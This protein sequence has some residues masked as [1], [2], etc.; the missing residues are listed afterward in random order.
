MQHIHQDDSSFE[1]RSHSIPIGVKNWS[2]TVLCRN[3]DYLVEGSKNLFFGLWPTYLP[4]PWSSIQIPEPPCGRPNSCKQD[5]LETRRASW[6]PLQWLGDV[7]GGSKP[8]HRNIVTAHHKLWKPFS[9][10]M[11]TAPIALES[12]RPDMVDQCTYFELVRWWKTREMMTAS[13][14]D[15][16][17][18]KFIK[19]LKR[20]FHLTIVLPI[21]FAMCAGP[22]FAPFAGLPLAQQYQWTHLCGDSFAGEAIIQS[23]SLGSSRQPFMTFYYP[24]TPD[25]TAKIHY[26]DYVMTND[27]NA[28]TQTL[29]FVGAASQGVVPAD[30]RPNIQSVS[31]ASPGKKNSISAQ[32][33]TTINS[34]SI[35]VP[36]MTGTYQI[37]PYLNFSL[38]DSGNTTYLRA[39]DKEWQFIDDAPSFVLRYSSSDPR[40][41]LG[42]IAIETA[43]TERN[44]C[45]VLKVCLGS[46]KLGFDILAPLGVVFISQNNFAAYCTQPR[47]YNL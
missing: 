4:N 30:L 28:S 37:S 24:E 29:S 41:P 36:C 27:P 40:Q 20:T 12:T 9:C 11:F 43:V 44:R 10:R 3:T 39:V 35:P 21:A 19:Y 14:M 32:C 45:E 13:P 23:P 33:V 18:E 16:L 31:I 17:Y 6:S 1:I 22:L 42:S 34:T 7:E 5:L 2:L 15:K 8:N 26:F 47:I 25:S 46:R 38:Q